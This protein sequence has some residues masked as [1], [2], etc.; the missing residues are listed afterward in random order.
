MHDNLISLIFF[1]DDVLK[2]NYFK[3]FNNHPIKYKDK[4]PN[5]QK[6]LDNRYNDSD[7]LLETLYRIYYKIEIKP[8][9][10]T[11]GKPLVFHKSTKKQREKFIE[12]KCFQTYCSISC[13]MK[14]KEVIDKQN[15]T[16]LEKYG[17]VNNTKKQQETCLS[18]YG[19]NTL[20][21]DKN[22][23]E[24]ARK[25][26]LI[27]Y[28]VEIP[29]QSKIIKEKTKNTC[30]EKYGV[31]STL[32]L[33]K[34]KL[35]CNTKEAKRKE[36]LTKKKNNSFNKSK[37]EDICYELLKEKYSDIIRQYR[38]EEY[39]FNCDFYIPSLNLYIE[40][41]GSHFHKGHPFDENNPNDISELNRLNEKL[42]RYN[43]KSQYDMII[44]T[45]TNL[46]VRKRKIAKE[47]NLNWIEFFNINE[48]KEWLAKN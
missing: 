28:G 40:Y 45:W 10:K 2:N 30:L 34:C 25:T 26:S 21:K 41:Q 35:R 4:Y 37:P 38:S 32:N 47:N 17:S 16:C 8:I 20:F 29:S 27:K 12:N 36:Y 24:K 15:N 11:C 19:V 5:I 42:N 6:Y 9:C 7:S 33:D 18:K 23:R 3:K 43:K 1:K 13:E 22:A 48:L 39:P 46:D 31:S 14:D 44:Y